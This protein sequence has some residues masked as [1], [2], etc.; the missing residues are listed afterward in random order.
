MKGTKY[1]SPIGLWRV[2]TEGDCEGKTVHDLGIYEGHIVDIAR[3]LSEEVF[4]DLHFTPAQKASEIKRPKPQASVSISLGIESGSW[5]LHNTERIAEFSH[6][7]QKMPAN[8]PY[9]FTGDTSYAGVTLAF[10]E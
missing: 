1:Q 7:L 8:T 4:Y 2:T 3:H 6:F 5:D 10:K 9:K